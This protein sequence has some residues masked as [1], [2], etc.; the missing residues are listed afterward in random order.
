MADNITWITKNGKHIPLI[1][2]K[3]INKTT[4]DYMNNKIRE[5][6]K[7]ENNVVP[8]TTNEQ[9][10]AISDKIQKETENLVGKQ[11]SENGHLYREDYNM[12]EDKKTKIEVKYLYRAINQKEYDFIQKNG[13][14]K[15]NGN[16]NLTDVEKDITCYKDKSP[17]VYLPKEG[18]GYILKIKIKPENNFF[19]DSDEYA[20]TKNKIPASQIVE[21]NGKKI[22]EG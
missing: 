21:I 12:F 22:K 15:S 4:N 18:N 6:K 8:I 14:I 5:K 1:N 19:Y 10:W 16:M 9:K 2:G 13:Y 7:I 20:K 17:M 11:V 3:P